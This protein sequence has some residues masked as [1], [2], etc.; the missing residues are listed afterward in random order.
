MGENRLTRWHSLPMFLG[1]LVATLLAGGAVTAYAAPQYSVNCSTCHSMPPLDDTTRNVATGGFVGNHTRHANS[2]ATSCAKCHGSGVTSYTTSHRSGTIDFAANI[3]SSP[4]TGQYKVG[5]TAITFKN[6]TSVP[7]V[8]S[9][10]SVNCHFESVTPT[11]GAANFSSTA[12]CQQCHASP[13][14]TVAVGHSKHDTYFPLS[15][16]GCKNCHPDYSSSPIFQHATSAGE[17]PLKVVLA[18]GTYSGT[19][20]NYLPSQSASRTLGGCT[21]LYCHSP[22]DRNTST[23][24]APNQAANWGGS[25]LACNGCHKYDVASGDPIVTPAAGFGHTKHVNS[26]I[27]TKIAC[28][29]CHSGTVN[30]AGVII[31]KA[32]H[33]DNVNKQVTIKFANTTSAAA[34]LYKGQAAATVAFKTAAGSYGSCTNVYCHSDG[35]KATAPF[36]NMSTPKW[37]SALAGNCAGCHGGNGTTVKKMATGSHTKHIAGGGAAGYT[38]GCVE[39]HS[40]TVSNDTTISNPANHLN[41]AINV[42]LN[43]GGTYSANGH[44]PGGAVGT[45]SATFCHSNGAGTYTTPTWGNAATG[46]CGSCHGVV[47]GTPP[48]SASHTKHVGTAY[49]YLFS[50]ATCHVRVVKNTTNSTIQATMSSAKLHIT[51]THS[52]NFNTAVTLAGAYTTATKTCTNIYCHSNGTV[53]AGSTFTAISTATWGRSNTAGCGGCHSYPPAYANG[54]PKANSHAKHASFTCNNCHNNTTTNGTTISNTANH[55]NKVYDVAPG[56]TTTFTLSNTPAPGTPA[57]CSNISC[58]GGTGSSATWGAT[59]NCQDCHGN[60]STASFLTYS[61][62]FWSG[63]TLAKIQMTGSGSWATNGHGLASGTY[64]GTNNPAAAFTATAACEYCHDST[65][66]HKD[67][68]NPFRLRNQV[69]AIWGRNGVCQSCHAV[70][71]AGVTVGGVLRNGTVKVG[72]THHGA[73]HLTATAG[74]QYCWDCHNGH[75]ANGT[76]HAMIRTAVAVTNDG[77]YGIP[78]T[79]ATVAFTLSA[80]PTGTDFVQAT[81]GASTKICQACHSTT[82]HYTA[83]TSDS[84]NITSNCI[85]CHSHTNSSNVNGAFAPAQCDACHGYPPMP[86]NVA[87]TFGRMNNYTSA[88]FEDYSGGGGAHATAAHVKLTAKASDG[89]TNCTPCHYNQSATHQMITPVRTHVSNINVTINPKLRFNN[90]TFGKYSGAK[91]V[92]PYA[93]KTGSCYSVACHFSPSPKWST[94]K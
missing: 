64:P 26:T 69:D 81:N 32:N 73:K 33:V 52:V 14:T 71:S 6:Q 87:V 54:S 36:T 62:N 4:A 20:L 27:T 11:W 2:S 9:C 57:Q 48:A 86:R 91:L 46:A 34:G 60:G 38:L 10:S 78:Q 30:S 8:G 68:T 21:N 19:G 79:F 56:G 72:S 39:C 84:H 16:N 70:G 85:A 47:A 66:L 63:T 42:V 22:G 82:N 40:A 83:T 94:E 53:T 93:N 7:V 49:N 89:W 24:N 58:H 80:T 92:N 76:N 61:A 13:P 90:V 15:A 29:K 51:G 59:L 43:S 44:Q 77:V 37:G 25:S 41:Y 74:G 65:V 12:D 17:R 31:N 3:N 35:T 50:C 5:G 45:C 1:C 75:G 28:Y 18:E 88:K 55:V 67:G 23:Y